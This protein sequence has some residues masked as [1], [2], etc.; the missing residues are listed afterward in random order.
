MAIACWQSDS[1]TSPHIPFSQAGTLCCAS[2]IC[3]TCRFPPDY[4]HQMSPSFPGHWAPGMPA[5][6]AHPLLVRISQMSQT[7]DGPPPLF[8]I[9]FVL[10]EPLLPLSPCFRL[11]PSC[12]K[13]GEPEKQSHWSR[14][15]EH[16]SETS[17]ALCVGPDCLG[18]G[19][20][21]TSQEE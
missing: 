16:S 18:N 7:P 13:Q 15:M 8:R 10:L 14:L 1:L 9:S 12:K 21:Q 4:S 3:S 17:R 20:A 5:V 2:A 11:L 19:S 6:P